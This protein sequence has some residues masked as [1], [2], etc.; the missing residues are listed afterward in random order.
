M[1]FGVNRNPQ[2]NRDFLLHVF[3]FSAKASE[4]TFDPDHS[5]NVLENTAM[6][7]NKKTVSI[8]QESRGS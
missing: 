6:L 7:H 1:H 8:T 5:M 3:V 2:E 4:M